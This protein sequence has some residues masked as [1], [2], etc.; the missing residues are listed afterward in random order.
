MLKREINKKTDRRLM[1][2]TGLPPNFTSD[3]PH[4]HHRMVKGK[5]EVGQSIR[6]SQQE[7][8]VAEFYTV[9]DWHGGSGIPLITKVLRVCKL[10]ARYFGNEVVYFSQLRH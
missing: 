7:V 1:G 5:C 3:M 8:T 9:T 2:L 6:C 4:L 10:C